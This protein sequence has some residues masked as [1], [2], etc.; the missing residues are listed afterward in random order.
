MILTLGAT[1]IDL[2]RASSFTPIVKE[3]R[4]TELKTAGGL[5][6]TQTWDYYE[7]GGYNFDFEWL[8]KSLFE[9]FEGFVVFDA[10]GSRNSFQMTLDDGTVYA[11]CKFTEKGKI[12]VG[13][14]E[15]Q[16]PA[17][18]IMENVYLDVAFGVKIYA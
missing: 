1:V 6:Y 15:T 8:E 4:Q 5:D 10:E 9:E 14:M 7:R 12:T 17:G 16:T 11:E 18:G 13:E 3:V 2:G